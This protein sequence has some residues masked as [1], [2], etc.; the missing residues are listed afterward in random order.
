LKAVCIGGIFFFRLLHG[1]GIGT[2]V[3]TDSSQ[4]EQPK[5]EYAY[6]FHWFLGT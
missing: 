1:V 6:A 3:A 5:A 2:I 4:G